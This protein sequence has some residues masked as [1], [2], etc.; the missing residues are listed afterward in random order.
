M[1]PAGWTP[2]DNAAAFRAPLRAVATRAPWSLPYSLKD[3]ASLLWRERFLMLA[4]FLAVF[5][6]AAAFSTTMKKSYTAYSAVLVKLGQEYVYEPRVGDAGRGAAATSGQIIQSELS[7]LNST[8][9]KERAIQ[10]IGLARI[11]P[12]LGAAFDKGGRQQK[13]LAFDAA[14]RALGEGLKVQTAPE[15]SVVQLS[16]SHEDP[17]MAAAVLNAL[18][19]EYLNYRKSVLVGDEPAVLEE[20]RRLFARRLADAE[21]AYQQFL[22]DAGIGDFENEKVSLSQVYASLLTE[23]YSIQAQLSEVQGRLGVTS[24]QASQAQPEIGLYQDTDATATSRLSTLKV[25]RQDLLSRYRPDSQPVREIDQK[26][27]ALETLIT[28][29]GAAG[30]AARRIGPNPVYQTLTTERNQLEAQAASLRSRQ[31]AVNADLA[32]VTAKRQRLVML[33]PRNQEL[34][35]NR[36]VLAT[37]VRNFTARAQE[38]QAA[39]AV[40]M[41][42]DDAIRV[43]ERAYTPTKGKSMKKAVLALGF[44]FGAFTALCA[45]AA[46][47]FLRRGFV[48]AESTAR[49]LELPVLG[50]APLKRAGA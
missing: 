23:R 10:K 20:Q 16:F 3:F 35:R 49:S 47:I 26:I 27:A 22:A 9:V 6:A 11:Y 46:R 34:V 50:S 36:D 31:A 12:K 2:T 4:V 37:N 48:T 25:E 32:Q 44:L 33:E 29:G 15:T 40:A 28:Q 13:R 45:A 42:G 41:E 17:M 18:V 39:R 43:V 19:E 14:V 5:V 1:N 38:S 7:I 30:V 24:R 21:A 8:A